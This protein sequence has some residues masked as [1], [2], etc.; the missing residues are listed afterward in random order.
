MNQSYFVYFL[1]LISLLGIQSCDIPVEVDDTKVFRLNRYENVSS[2]DPAF[3]RSKSNNWM[4]NL[5]YTGLVNFDD[6]LH[7]IPELSLI[8]I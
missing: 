1:I 8:H 4:A 6:S 2:L 7:I 3:A 5:M